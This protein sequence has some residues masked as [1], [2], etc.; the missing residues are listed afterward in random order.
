MPDGEFYSRCL[1]WNS[2]NYALNHLIKMDKSLS[3]HNVTQRKVESLCR[4]QKINIHSESNQPRSNYIKNAT[5]LFFYT[6]IPSKDQST[7]TKAGESNSTYYY[8]SAE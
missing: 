5:Q 3:N 1:P 4:R 8:T 2:K 7:E 6:N